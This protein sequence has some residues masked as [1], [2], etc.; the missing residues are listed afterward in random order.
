MYNIDGEIEY[1]DSYIYDHSKYKSSA[2]FEVSSRFLRSSFL[3]LKH[4]DTVI[5]ICNVNWAN[6][7]IPGA[8]LKGSIRLTLRLNGRNVAVFD[9]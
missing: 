3:I 1:C 6:R 2:Y 4:N 8:F 5:N 9:Q 7:K